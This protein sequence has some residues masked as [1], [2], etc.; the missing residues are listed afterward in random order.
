MVRFKES[1]ICYYLFCIMVHFNYYYY[2]RVDVQ[3]L[4]RRGGRATGTVKLMCAVEPPPWL[5]FETCL[6]V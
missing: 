3:W 5:H 2:L 6:C 1:H 4:L